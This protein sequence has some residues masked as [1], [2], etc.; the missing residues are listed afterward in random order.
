MSQKELDSLV[1]IG[2]LKRE[3]FAQSEV[4]TSLRSGRDRLKDAS[5]QGISLAGKF[6]RGNTVLRIHFLWLP[7]ENGQVTFRY[8]NGKTGKAEFPTLGGVAFLKRF[9]HTFC[10]RLSLHT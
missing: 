3:P 10:P 1:K 7:C 4:D 2:Q 8:T 6:L 9:V 5:A